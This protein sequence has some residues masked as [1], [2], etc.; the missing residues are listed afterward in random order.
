MDDFVIIGERNGEAYVE[1]AAPVKMIEPIVLRVDTTLTLSPV[2]DSMGLAPP[3]SPIDLPAEWQRAIPQFYW[4]T[5]FNSKCECLL[6]ENCIEPHQCYK[7]MWTE[8]P[9]KY[10][11]P[12]QHIL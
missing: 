3:L 4:I 11:G 1:V 2:Q 12:H 9:S 5:R 6:Y 10:R 7:K 8:R